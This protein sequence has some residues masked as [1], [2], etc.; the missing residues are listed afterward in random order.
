M[1]DGEASRWAAISL[2]VPLRRHDY[3]LEW[4]R[5]I[6]MRESGVLRSAGIYDF[7]FLS[8]FSYHIDTAWLWAFC[9]RWN[10]SIN[11]LFINDHE[12][13]LTLWEIHQLLGL[14]IF[15]YYYDEYVV[16][17]DDLQDETR[18]PASL[19]RVYEIYYRLRMRHPTV[20]FRHWISYFTDRLHGRPGSSASLRDPFGTGQSCIYHED[21]ALPQDSFYSHDVDRETYLTAFLA[22]WICYFLLPSSPIYSIRP[23]VFV[24]A[25]RITRGDRVSLAVPVLA[26]IYRVLRGLTSSHSPSHCRE[27]IPWHL[28][29]GWLHMHWSGLYCPS[30]AS[31]LRD[32]LPLLSD[33]AGIQPS[34][35]TAEDA[36]YRFY[37][38]QDHLRFAHY[39]TLFRALRTVAGGDGMHKKD[40]EIPHKRVFV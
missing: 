32:E 16:L 11:T 4:T 23:S 33:L 17:E 2:V 29:S 25:S 39:A 12:M 1:I 13:T 5:Y 8:M 34:S 20:P 26:N 18:F 15:G 22:W 40:T 24:M 37:M 19:R 10:Y 31:D 27:I 35:M 14:P 30:L 3:Q 38:S 28:I 9:E 6:L 21:T 7:I 36:R